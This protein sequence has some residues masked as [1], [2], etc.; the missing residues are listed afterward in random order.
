MPQKQEDEELHVAFW[1]QPP[2]CLVEELLH[3]ANAKAV[4]DLTAGAGP[5]ALAAIEQWCC[6]MC[7]TES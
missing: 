1:Y 6:R 2:R 4:I 5:W 7:T 3:L